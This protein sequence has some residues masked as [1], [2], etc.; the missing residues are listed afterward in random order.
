[1]FDTINGKPRDLTDK[2]R[3]ICTGNGEN[4]EI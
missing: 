1:M 4:R 2:S 3:Q